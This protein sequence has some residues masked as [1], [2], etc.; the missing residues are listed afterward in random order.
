MQRITEGN[1]INDA[2]SKLLKNVFSFELLSLNICITELK[3]SVNK[4][5]KNNTIKD[6]VK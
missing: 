5:R 3:R 4:R 2:P 6:K 1:I